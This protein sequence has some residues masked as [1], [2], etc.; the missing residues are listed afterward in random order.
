MA[1][2]AS[3]ETGVLLRWSEQTAPAFAWPPQ[4]AGRPLIFDIG[5]NNGRDSIEFVRSG[6][7]VVAV[8]GNPLM[9]SNGSRMFQAFERS[10]QFVMLGALLSI[11]G[12]DAGRT[13]PFYVHQLHH[14]WS[15][16]DPAEGCRG[17]AGGGMTK[18]EPNVARCIVH[19][20]PVIACRALIGRFGVPFYLKID[21]EGA[22]DACLN[23]LPALA[24][25]G[26]LPHYLSFEHGHGA[27]AS[28]MRRL[29]MLE[30]LGY[31]RLKLVEQWTYGD[32]S[33]PY[34]DLA[35][36]NHPAVREEHVRAS[37]EFGSERAYVAAHAWHR[38]RVWL[39]TIAT[40]SKASSLCRSW[41]DFHLALEDDVP[42]T[43]RYALQGHPRRRG[44]HAN[45]YDDEA[46]LA[47]HGGWEA[48]SIDDPGIRFRALQNSSSGRAIAGTAR[49]RPGRFFLRVLP[50]EREAAVQRLAVA[51]GVAPSSGDGARGAGAAEAEGVA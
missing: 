35:L 38:T 11:N 7:R 17:R 44:A 34:G 28:W 29:H 40:S 49:E 47:W 20:V 36:D 23:E 42:A 24:R 10:G 1:S 31:T 46:R 43:T 27:R 51:R 16:M 12:S 33:G 22:E 37:K 48:S 14:E 26:Q 45:P 30:A 15:S 25:A 3:S 13:L 21:I 32:W 8:E 50:D 5:F 2:S 9:S 4:H 41:C 18:K 19:H 39:A 6:A